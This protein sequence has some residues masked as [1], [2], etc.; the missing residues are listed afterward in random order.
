V[1]SA[2]TAFPCGP[3]PKTKTRPLTPGL[4]CA[5]SVRAGARDCVRSLRAIAAGLAFAGPV[6]VYELIACLVRVLHRTKGIRL[7]ADNLIRAMI[8]DL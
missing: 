3:N 4:L 8:G 2:T 1:S 6:V 7:S 5:V